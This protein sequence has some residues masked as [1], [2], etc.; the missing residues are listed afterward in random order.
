VVN[1]GEYHVGIFLIHRLADADQECTIEHDTVKL[2]HIT[3]IFRVLQGSGTLVTGGTLANAKPIAPNDPDRPLLGTGWRGSPIEGGETHRVREGDLIIIPSG[4]PH[5]F[6]AIDGS[7][8]L[9]VER[10]DM[11]KALP[12]K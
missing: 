8:T 10:I 3:E 4:V 11:G 7:I 2:D 9:L 12:I 5:G 1:A 6:C